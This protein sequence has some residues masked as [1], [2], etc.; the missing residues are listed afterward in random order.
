MTGGM[1]PLNVSAVFAGMAP[2]SPAALNVTVVIMVETLR[3]V[4][5]A[6]MFVPL[7]GMPGTMPTLP[8][9][10]NQGLPRRAVPRARRAFTE[11]V[12]L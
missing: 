11:A 1:P 4:A 2:E 10:E 8:P 9:V 6:A 12:T 5:P 3:T 7:A